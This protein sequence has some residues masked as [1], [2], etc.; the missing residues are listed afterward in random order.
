MVGDLGVECHCGC[1]WFAKWARLIGA[2]Q[3]YTTT[4][5][6]QSENFFLLYFVLSEA[7]HGYLTKDKTPC[8]TVPLTR[9]SSVRHVFLF[10]L[11]ADEQ[12]LHPRGAG[13]VFPTTRP[14]DVVLLFA[15]L[16][17]SPDT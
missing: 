14:G 10:I 17:L 5:G 12:F 1:G 15:A 16:P 6:P 8:E 13:L 2:P 7:K 11:R 9:L 4:G 3:I